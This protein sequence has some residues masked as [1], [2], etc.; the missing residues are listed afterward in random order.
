MA[1][2]SFEIQI[3][4]IAGSVN[5]LPIAKPLSR[6]LGLPALTAVS[7][8]TALHPFR[9]CNCKVGLVASSSCKIKCPAR[10][11]S[12]IQIWL[13]FLSDFLLRYESQACLLLNATAPAWLN[14]SC[15]DGEKAKMEFLGRLHSQVQSSI[16][17]MCFSRKASCLYRHHWIM[18]LLA[19]IRLCRWGFRPM[20]GMY[21]PAYDSPAMKNAREASPACCLKKCC[22]ATYTSAAISSSLSGI[23]PDPRVG[24]DWEGML[25]R[26]V[27]GDYETENWLLSWMKQT[28]RLL[29]FP[30]YDPEVLKRT[31]CDFSP[32][33]QA[34]F[35]PNCF[36]INPNIDP[37]SLPRRSSE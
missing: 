10:C 25:W 26:D 11:R 36:T 27:N 14:H 3:T 15:S 12:A 19:K 33:F 4:W 34:P 32:P 20:A 6:N 13:N 18:L 1:T 16:Q 35:H 28:V 9:V 24:R 22:K 21:F 31:A 37:P 2:A 30:A 23:L 5:P 29:A 17:G 7:W 8:H